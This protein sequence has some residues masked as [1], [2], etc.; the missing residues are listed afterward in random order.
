M[1]IV[2]FTHFFNYS[3]SLSS[4]KEIIWTTRDLFKGG[5]LSKCTSIGSQKKRSGTK[6]IY[7][8][9]SNPVDQKRIMERK[10]SYSVINIVTHGYRI[11]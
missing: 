6:S 3:K 10:L 8:N 2:P 4:P 5:S 1:V 11:I 9:S 7:Q